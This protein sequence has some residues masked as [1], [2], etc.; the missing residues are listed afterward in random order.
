MH[1][2]FAADSPLRQV[3]LRT[4]ARL[5]SRDDVKLVFLRRRLSLRRGSDA[6][7]AG[8]RFSVFE[9]VPKGA[10]TQDRLSLTVAEPKS[11]EGLVMDKDAAAED[12]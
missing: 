12:R 4:R 11:Y 2:T 9:I 5:L 7:R 8:A 6:P 10:D 1:Y 3:G